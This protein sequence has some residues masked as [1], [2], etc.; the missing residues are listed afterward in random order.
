MSKLGPY[1]NQYNWE[2]LEFPLAIKEI[3][4][5]EKNNPGIVVNVLFS[6]KKSQKKNIYSLQVRA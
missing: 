3:N 6:N 1:E 4:M 2:D 5:F